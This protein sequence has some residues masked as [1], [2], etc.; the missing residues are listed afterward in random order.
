MCLR[1]IVSWFA[2]VKYEQCA[3]HLQLL[4]VKWIYSTRQNQ[5]EKIITHIT[6]LLAP[7]HQPDTIMTIALNLDNLDRHMHGLVNPIGR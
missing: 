6:K 2:L 7:Q 5:S 3:S 4:R 1:T